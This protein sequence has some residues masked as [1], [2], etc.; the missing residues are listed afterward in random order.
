MTLNE[1][2]DRDNIFAKIIRGEMPAVKIAETEETLA[3]MDVFPQSRGHC[4]II[5][6]NAPA[7]TL[8]EIDADTLSRLIIETQRIARAVKKSLQPDGVRIMQF[9]GA[10]AGQT[11]FHI[12]FHIVPIFEGESVKPHAG[13]GPADADALQVVADR[14][15]AAL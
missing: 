1:A 3:F 5:P 6:K 4:L 9:N 15:I 13:G 10:P 14:V 8:F 2:Y 11:I 12:H 7:T